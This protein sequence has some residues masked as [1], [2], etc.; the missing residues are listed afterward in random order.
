CVRSLGK[1]LD[2]VAHQVEYDVL[3]LDSVDLQTR[4]SIAELEAVLHIVS[5]RIRSHQ[6]GKLSDQNVDLGR[7]GPTDGPARQAAQP[8]DDVPGTH[9][10]CRDLFQGAL[11]LFEI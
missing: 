7:L 4:Q 3:N 9:R 1:G 6:V 5:L 2:G 8:T 10:L 11:Y